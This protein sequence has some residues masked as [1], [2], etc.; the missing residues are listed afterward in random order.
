MVAFSAELFH[1]EDDAGGGDAGEGEGEPVEGVFVC[2]A[3]VFHPEHGEDEGCDAEG[4]VE[5]EDPVPGG[6]LLSVGWSEPSS[7]SKLV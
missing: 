4:K 2:E 3:K 7:P 5:E 6:E 1:G